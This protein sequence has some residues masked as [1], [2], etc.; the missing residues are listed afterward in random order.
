MCKVYD[1]KWNKYKRGQVW[2]VQE[3]PEITKALREHGS[4]VINGTRP[5]FVVGANGCHVTCIPMTTN[6]TRDIHADDDIV[7]RSDDSESRLICSQICTKSTNDFVKYMYTFDE[8]AIQIIMKS[9]ANFLGMDIFENASVSTETQKT[10]PTTLSSKTPRNKVRFCSKE[11]TEIV[12]KWYARVS[13]RTNKRDKIFESDKEAI[14]FCNKYNHIRNEDLANM[15]GGSVCV[16]KQW[17][18]NA[19]KI[20]GI[21][22][23]TRK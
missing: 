2:V 16:A 15:L 5:Y 21:S 9:I 8:E 22:Y 20:A 1:L 11:D 4:T 13:T 18:A 12:N 23:S 17:K 10:D 19:R 3:D 14:A 6:T 7:F